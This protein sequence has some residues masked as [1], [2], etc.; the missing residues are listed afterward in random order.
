MSQNDHEIVDASVL[1]R[2]VRVMM[3]YYY[4]LHEGEGR[5]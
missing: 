1:V 3:R 5:F 2:T 4:E